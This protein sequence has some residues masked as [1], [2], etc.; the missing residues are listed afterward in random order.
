[1]LLPPNSW[2]ELHTQLQHFEA[3][4]W[5]ALDYETTGLDVVGDDLAVGVGLA[6]PTEAVYVPF[7]GAGPST[8]LGLHEWLQS[9][10][11]VGHN[12]CFDG[13]VFQQFCPNAFPWVADTY[14]LFRWLAT[15]DWLG[16]SW[17]LKTA[18]VDLLGW[19]APNTAELDAW[20]KANKLS[21][22]ELHRAP[23]EVLGRYCAL[24][25]GA[26]AQLYAYFQT[27]LAKYPRLKSYAEN[28]GLTVLKH[29]LTQTVVGQT[30]DRP[31]LE[32]YQTKLAAGIQDLEQQF[33]SHPKVAWAVEVYNGW[34]HDAWHESRPPELTKA[35]KQTARYSKW[36]EKEKD[37]LSTQHFNVNS[38]QQLVW[39]FYEHLH[40]VDGGT[41]LVGLDGVEVPL[42]KGGGYSVDKNA[43]GY[44]GEPGNL[45]LKYNDANTELK[46]VVACLERS[47]R[48]GKL[49]VSLKVP[50]TS[51]GRLSGGSVE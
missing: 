3:A 43:L 14:S 35:G 40:Q 9:R 41:L 49:H 36:L 12:V 45:L 24:D 4:P 2:A 1:M 15:E 10:R 47:A 33:L 21:K 26:T 37:V 7:D 23:T 19:D 18:M 27:V 17:S 31:K 20:L 8:L 44:F 30:I 34:Q 6:T 51:T 50:G 16:Q 13:L 5:L 28:E 25:A 48:D 42:T 32:A 29:S 46:F 38:K 22:A 11:L 39:L